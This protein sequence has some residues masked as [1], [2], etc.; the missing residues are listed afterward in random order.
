M[1]KKEIAILGVIAVVA[2][3]AIAW[4]TVSRNNLTE[5]D[6]TS[7]TAPSAKPKGKWVAIVHGK[8]VERWFDSGV[9]GE[10]EVTGD[11]GV[12]HVEVKDGKW[13]VGDVE[14]PNQICHN[15][16]WDDGSGFMPITCI[17]NNIFIGTEEWVEGYLEP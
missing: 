1:K 2:A 11:Y 7:E 9:D 17:P 13:C 8:D 14:C 3:G 16:G 15:M 5:D 4:T 12:M 6:L 10:Y